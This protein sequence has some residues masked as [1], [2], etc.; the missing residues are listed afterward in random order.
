MCNHLVG[1]Q[2]ELKKHLKI[3]TPPI[4]GRF[5][6]ALWGGQLTLGLSSGRTLNLQTNLR[7]WS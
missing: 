1:N 2:E 6:L 7:V 4:L 3:Q 5:G